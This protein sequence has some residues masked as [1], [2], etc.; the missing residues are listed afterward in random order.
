MGV[1]ACQQRWPECFHLSKLSVHTVNH[2]IPHGSK[3]STTEVTNYCHKTLR[4]LQQGRR[5]LMDLSFQW[6]QR[7]G[8]SHAKRDSENAFICKVCAIC[9][10][11]RAR[12]AGP[13]SVQHA[14]IPCGTCL[15]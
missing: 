11:C 8:L 6:L 10:S 7:W 15:L 5:P 2:A 3:C 14:Y 13:A 4:W 1:T 12:C 9:T